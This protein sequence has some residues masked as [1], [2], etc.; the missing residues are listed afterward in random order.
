MLARVPHIPYNAPSAIEF[1]AAERK[2]D[3][4]RATNLFFRGAL[5]CLW[6]MARRARD[7]VNDLDNAKSCVRTEVSQNQR[8]GL[9]TRVRQYLLERVR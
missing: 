9:N 5:L 8:G 4:K 1:F 7:A 6:S 3:A 2:Q